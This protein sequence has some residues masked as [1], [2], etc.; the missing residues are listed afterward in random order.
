MN[1]TKFKYSYKNGE[2]FIFT[3]KI[4]KYMLYLHPKRL[5]W[6]NW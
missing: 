6:W 4:Q 5:G 2:T 3:Q 1:K